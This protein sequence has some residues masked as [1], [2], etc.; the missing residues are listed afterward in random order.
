MNILKQY[1]LDAAA[2]DG[3]SMDDDEMVMEQSSI[4]ELEMEDAFEIGMGGDG[5]NA[6]H[7]RETEEQLEKMKAEVARMKKVCARNTVR[8]ARAPPPP[9]PLQAHGCPPGEGSAS[10]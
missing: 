5:V 3:A 1:D 6:E 4:A 7:A 8:C 2:H 10:I 9:L